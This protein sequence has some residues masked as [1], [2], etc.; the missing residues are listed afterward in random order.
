MHESAQANKVAKFLN[1]SFTWLANR[2]VGWYL[3]NSYGFD[4]IDGQWRLIQK[5]ALDTKILVVARKHYKEFAKFYPVTNLR[6]IKQVLAEEY[7]GVD[8]VYHLIGDEVDNQRQVCSFVIEPQV[9]ALFPSTIAFVPETLLI[10]KMYQSEDNIIEIQHDSPYF[11]YCKGSIPISQLKQQLCPNSY[12]FILNNGLPDSLSA[13]QISATEHIRLLMQSLAKTIVS[14]WQLV[15]IRVPRVKSLELDLKRLSVALGILGVSYML[16]SSVYLSWMLTYREQQL[17]DLG[18]DVEQLLQMQEEMD[19][20]QNSSISLTQAKAEH[21]H[22]AHL[23][24]V[25]LE[26]QQHY[27]DLQITGL[28]SLSNSHTLRGTAKRATDIFTHLQK[29]EWVKEVRFDAPV[30]RERELELFVIEVELKQNQKSSTAGAQDA[31]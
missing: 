16:F 5:N 24:L 8:G 20:I 7:S 2:Y 1:N 26:L 11:M 10:W 12:G 15:F 28:S 3:D 22:S 27:P 25:V 9:F 4:V 17:V 14:N 13:K 29:S 31:E 23:W 19:Y 21:L 18:S 6:E 30:R